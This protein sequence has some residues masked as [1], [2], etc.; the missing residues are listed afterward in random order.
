MIKD[1]LR[2]LKLRPDVQDM[3]GNRLISPSNRT[4]LW[5]HLVLEDLRD[6]RHKRTKRGFEKALKSL[7]KP[8]EV[9]YEKILGRVNHNRRHKAEILLRIVVDA[10]R[11]LTLSEMDV[12]FEL[13]TGGQDAQ[14]HDDLDLGLDEDSIASQLRDLCGLFIYVDNSRIFLIHQSAREFLVNTHY[15]RLAP[16]SSW[17]HFQLL[18]SRNQLLVDICV[19]YLSLDD[20][21]YDLRYEQSGATDKESAYPFLE[22][23]TTY[24]AAH[25]RQATVHDEKLL[26]R[27][28]KIFHDRSQRFENWHHIFPD[29]N[30]FKG[31]PETALQLAAFNGHL[32]SV[33]YLLEAREFETDRDHGN[34]CKALYWAALRGNE[35]IVNILIE[36][37]A[38]V[39]A[40]IS[41]PQTTPNGECEKLKYMLLDS[42]ADE[43]SRSL[44]TA[45][46]ED[47][48]GILQLLVENCTHPNEQADLSVDALSH[49]YAGNH[50]SH[51]QLSLNRQDISP[52]SAFYG[53]ALQAAAQGG[54]KEVVQLLLDRGADVNVSGGFFGNAL[55]AAARGGYSSIVD[56]LLVR[57]ADINAPCGFYGS[58]LQAA[59]RGG[60]MISVEDLVDEG[61]D[62]NASWGFYGT[63]LQ[64]AARVGHKKI[65]QLLISKGA[66]IN[67]QGGVY[68]TALQAAVAGGYEDIAILLLEKGANM[69]AQGGFYG[70]ILKAATQTHHQRIVQLLRETGFNYGQGGHRHTSHRSPF[71]TSNSASTDRRVDG[72]DLPTCTSLATFDADAEE[73]IRRGHQLYPPDLA[74]SPHR[75]DDD[76]SRPH[77]KRRWLP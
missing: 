30:N 5:A 29:T 41:A 34:M 40:K 17:P 77:K 38:D 11:P 2:K 69:H 62:V 43:I 61:A 63:P 71:E 60:H 24:L 25:F 31:A 10:Y 4:Y 7:P 68:G 75:R 18:K 56:L 36:N 35:Q 64:A 37:G 49:A 74:S 13:A 45:S 51:R 76:T 54:Y 23:S 39:D 46:S 8:L 22:Y 21:N 3:L 26:Q 16:D 19:Q 28:Y 66:D 44:L 52:Y 67:A 27:I 48:I 59:A 9:E 32:M 53:N 1:G 33:S 50:R 72:K 14:T 42:G 57:G 73:N 12:A 47:Y 20:F 55:Q 58:A 6:P 70:S 65:V 15:P